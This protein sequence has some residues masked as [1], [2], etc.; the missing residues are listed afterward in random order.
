MAQTI[1][2]SLVIAVGL[3][4]KGYKA[5]SK[6]VNED[7]NKLK[8]Q[9]TNTTKEFESQGK[10]AGSYFSEMRNE[11]GKLLAMFAGGVGMTAWLSTLTD[12]NNKLGLLSKNIGIS[13]TELVA[14][15]NAS[16]Q[17]GGSA[18]GM[19]NALY[20]LKQVQ[21][22]MQYGQVPAGIMG[23]SLLGMNPNDDP[24]KMIESAM[25]RLDELKAQGKSEADRYSLL[26]Q[27]G[28]ADEGLINL[29]L[30]GTR[31][32]KEQI[33][34]QMVLAEKTAK[35]TEKAAKF[36]AE[37]EHVGQEIYG[38]SQD[39]YN[40]VVPAIEKW[41]HSMSDL[42]N[43]LTNNGQWFKNNK[44]F[45]NDF[46]TI[47]AVVT[48]PL[49]TKALWSL[50]APFAPILLLIGA[51]AVLWQDY[52]KFEEGGNTAL[53]WAKWIPVLKDAKDGF[54][55][56]DESVNNL[57]KQL[58]DLMGIKL[59]T[60]LQTIAPWTNFDM[61]GQGFKTIT[62]FFGKDNTENGE[63]TLLGD[64]IGKGEGDYTSFNRGSKG[65]QILGSG[66]DQN[67]TNMTIGEIKAQ[68]QFHVEQQKK[69][70]PGQGL[71]AVGKYQ[72]IPET[73]N[74]V[75]KKAG[76]K[77][78]DKFTPE[79]QERL[80]KETLPKSFWQYITG[81][82]LSIDK[83]KKDLSGIWPSIG[84]KK[85]E[86]YGPN[87]VSTT[88]DKI[89]EALISMRDMNIKGLRNEPREEIT[90][91][92]NPVTDYKKDTSKRINNRSS[93]VKSSPINDYKKSTYQNNINKYSSV[94]NT[95]SSEVNN[96][97]SEVNINQITINTKTN[98]DAKILSNDLYGALSNHRLIAQADY[99]Q[100]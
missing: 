35:N 4:P 36:K 10:K 26:K 30:K 20:T 76:A 31:A 80:F 25:N 94:N 7:L 39:V 27:A 93:E 23:M 37:I 84:D 81:D 18:E 87:K 42:Y 67:L 53:P 82:L 98:N 3:D 1:I 62:D 90:S 34:A 9:A 55:D 45:I 91:W 66:K 73:F 22:G 100:N 63:R 40:I 15:S 69:G 56:L 85:G 41:L 13:A 14:W 89:E 28:F 17:M 70:V 49:L 60:W 86:S 97:K 51:L 8:K 44:D 43:Q 47:L 29:M 79:L 33:A 92:G 59:P 50:V 96:T 88:F 46:F 32:A 72:W 65:K 99:G 48:I 24:L 6:V 5:G 95:K 21:E 68:Q 75:T 71:F 74:S 38:F 54:D 77:D 2:D 12:S 78:T 83:V 52:Q 11:A 64:V 61:I 58:E 57:K 16:E 19:K